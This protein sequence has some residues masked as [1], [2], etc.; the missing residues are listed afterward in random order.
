M[1][2]DRTTKELG[3]EKEEE[4]E[5]GREGGRKEGIGIWTDELREEGTKQ[6]M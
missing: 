3:G 6:W 1:S 4:R 2:L 5:G